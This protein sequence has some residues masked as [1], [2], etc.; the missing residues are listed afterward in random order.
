MSDNYDYT[1]EELL[2]EAKNDPEWEADAEKRE[3]LVNRLK[4][5]LESV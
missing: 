1:I 2:E 4:V 3:S 5:I